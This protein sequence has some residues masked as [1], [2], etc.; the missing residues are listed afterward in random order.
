MTGK[1]FISCGQAEVDEKEA[2][3]KVSELLKREFN[4]DTYLAIHV[5][6]LDDIMMITEQLRSCDYFLF[7]DFKRLSVFTHQELA[8]AHHLGFGGEIIAL[9]QSGAGGMQGFLRY[10]LG[11]PAIFDTTD[12]LL[13]KV[14][15]LVRDKHWNQ[16]YS[17]N[18]VVSPSITRSTPVFIVIK[19]VNHI[20]SLGAQ[21]LRTTGPI[22]RQSE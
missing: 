15:E 7:V 9:R 18:L 14:R 2:A 11:N 13:T 20:T 21:R 22:R 8:L 12:D 3:A 17:R 16:H 1:V 19:Q 4:L 6:S 5:Q 10:V